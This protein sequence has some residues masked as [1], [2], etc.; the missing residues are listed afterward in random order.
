MEPLERKHPFK[1]VTRQNWLDPDPLSASFVQLD[2]RDG[3]IT[4]MD[5]ADWID[6][7]VEITLP[8]SV[9]TEVAN[10]FE[11]TKGGLGYGFF[12]YPL[13]TVVGQQ[14]LRVADFA[15]DRLFEARAIVPR[16]LSMARRLERLR[17][18][19]LISDEHFQQWD[20]IR[21][22]RNLATH[23]DF[24]HTWFPSDAVRTLKLVAALVSEL[25]WPIDAIQQERLDDQPAG[26]AQ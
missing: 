26:S 18:E 21:H 1:Y 25:P 2:H 7:V 14:V 15:I 19:G 9:P 6:A 12:Y 13:A 24:Q 22:M 10:A 11:F 20:V 4:P 8:A 16:P 5:G 23:P 17:L 3:S